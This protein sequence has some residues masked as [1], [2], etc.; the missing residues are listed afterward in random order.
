M[1]INRIKFVVTTLI[2]DYD[3]PVD[4]FHDLLNKYENFNAQH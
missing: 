2:Y 4:F 1:H 3:Y